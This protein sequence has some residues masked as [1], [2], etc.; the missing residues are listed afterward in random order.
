[1]RRWPMRV[2]YENVI[3]K[4][5]EIVFPWIAEPEKAM[6]WQKNVKGGEV[7][8]SKPG[9]VGT[10]FRETIEENGRRLE[11]HGTITEYAE[12]RVIGFHLQSRMHNVDVTYS[13]SDMNRQTRI[14]IVANI[15]WKFPMNIVSLFAGRNMAQNLTGQLE[16]EVLELK[17]I[18]ETL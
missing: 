5:P 9:M 6:K 2:T 17:R 3:S 15:R 7:I 14:G 11:M 12:N 10:T 16:S 18:C 8:V 1:M 13:V 4:P